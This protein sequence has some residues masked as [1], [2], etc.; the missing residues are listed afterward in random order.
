[1]KYRVRG[2]AAV[3]ATAL[4]AAFA[5]AGCFASASVA[6]AAAAPEVLFEQSSLDGI[7]GHY[8][9]PTAEHRPPTPGVF[10]IL[11]WQPNPNRPDGT[12]VPTDWKAGD[13]TGFYPSSPLDRHQAGFRNAPGSTTLQ[14]DG[15]TVGAY[16][17]S[18]DLPQGS[19]LFKM[20][21]TPEMSV[22]PTAQVQPFAQSG[23]VIVVSLDLQVPT[24]VDE[25]RDGSETYVG[26]DLLFIDR[27]KG[28][29]ISYGCNLFFNG[30]PHREAGGHIRIDEDSQN[31][32][33]NSVVGLDN[34]WLVTL[35]GSAVSQ[36][37]PWTG[38]K[39]FRF[40]ISEKNFIDA[41][42]AYNQRVAGAQVSLQPGDYSFAKFHL[43]A[44]MHFKSSPTEL[45]WSMRRAKIEVL[46]SAAVKQ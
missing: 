31:M 25:H 11:L 5:A 8:S 3:L 6:T 4:Q 32:M 24:A 9:V 37:E 34:E 30:H 33:V 45:G 19:H 12:L 44:E 35:P 29:R 20:M 10:H 46:D 38:W 13:K 14:I 43:N 27:G 15:D 36:S 28:T 2:L 18:A 40:A 42:N 7:E 1:M 41:L 23:R 16:I 17:K 22:P 26:A 39:T 21:M